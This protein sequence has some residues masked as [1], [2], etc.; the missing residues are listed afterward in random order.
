M[1]LRK[2]SKSDGSL[3]GDAPDVIWEHNNIDTRWQ[4]LNLEAVMITGML[5]SNTWEFGP[6]DTTD[7][8]AF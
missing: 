4:F 1:G 7:Y 3:L 8:Y 2:I 5:A 6:Q